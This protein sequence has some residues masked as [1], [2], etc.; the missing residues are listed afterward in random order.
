MIRI[1]SK[2]EGFRR[3]GMAHSTKPQ[4]YP[5]HKFSKEQIAAL[6]AEP[7]LKVEIINVPQALPS[8]TPQRKG[9]KQ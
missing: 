3:A 5:D 6:Q 9:T 7:M 1:T 8:A 2:V 4:E